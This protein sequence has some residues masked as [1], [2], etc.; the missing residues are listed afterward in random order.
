MSEGVGFSSCL[1]CGSDNIRVDYT[2]GLVVCRSCGLVLQNK[3]VTDAAEWRSFKD[4]P[5]KNQRAAKVKMNPYLSHGSQIQTQMM[6]SMGSA[7]GK[8]LYAASQ[9]A[10]T[11]MDQQDQALGKIFKHL[12]KF[13]VNTLKRD[14]RS[15]D[16]CM[17]IV[18]SLYTG[19]EEGVSGN[20]LGAGVGISTTSGAGGGSSSSTS[21]FLNQPGNQ[22]P[23]T[24]FR[25]RGFTDA[26]LIFILCAAQARLQEPVGIK[27]IVNFLHERN[28][29]FGVEQKDIE[30]AHKKFEKAA[31]ELLRE[32]AAGT[33]AAGSQLLIG[34]MKTNEDPRELIAK[35]VR[36]TTGGA[37]STSLQD[38]AELA[39]RALQS[40]LQNQKQRS[41]GKQTV[42][43]HLHQ[44]RFSVP[45]LAAVAQNDAAGCAASVFLVAVLARVV[46]L[47]TKTSGAV[48]SSAAQHL[49][50]QQDSTG[51]I[52]P[53]SKR[54]KLD[55]PG[56]FEQLQHLFPD[57]DM[58]QQPAIH[59]ALRIYLT[60]CEENLQQF[61]PKGRPLLCHALS[62]GFQQ[63]SVQNF[64][65]EEG[66]NLRKILKRLFPVEEWRIGLRDDQ[67]PGGE[68]SAPRRE[69]TTGGTGRGP[70]GPQPMQ[71]G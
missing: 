66:D 17:R 31:P 53:N 18:H 38:E 3:I 52:F 28:L 55:E 29:T 59:T 57:I 33:S 35:Y 50:Y 26:D 68:I 51:G 70:G 7:V 21:M 60:P 69:T 9:N 4:E 39:F 65:A 45:A 14:E 43:D 19:A 12:R 64:A 20:N 47:K 71:V 32:I 61:K 15:L 62:T 67:Q 13:L 30:A 6:G 44:Y 58:E 16:E 1:Y 49:L 40:F 37:S 27:Q 42:T 56:A 10:S 46:Q 25:T 2:E 36:A 63:Q 54:R 34:N 24:I 22:P 5:E 48:S 41:H 23:K 8:A 11:L